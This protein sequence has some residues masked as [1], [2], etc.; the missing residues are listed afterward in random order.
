MALQDDLYKSLLEESQLYREKVSAIWLQ[1]FTLL[2]AVIAF[3]VAQSQ[4]STGKNPHLIA[5]AILA[6]PVVAVLLDIKLGEF[7]IQAN[8]IDH[9]V[10]L[11]YRE[12]AVLGEWEGTKW[13]VGADHADRRLIRIRSILTLAVTVIPTCI[14]AVLSAMDVKSLPELHPPDYL[15]TLAFLFCVLYIAAGIISIPFLLFRR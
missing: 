9:F 5:A 13:G 14:I 15:M 3:V 8:V 11:H 4:L 2:G 7:G 12:P 1:K 6:L 10:R